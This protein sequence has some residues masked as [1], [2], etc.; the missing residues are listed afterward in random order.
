MATAGE[1]YTILQ[2]AVGAAAVV[3]SFIGGII[4]TVIGLKPRL[5][6][7]DDEQLVTKYDLM[8]AMNAFKEEERRNRHDLYG[9]MQRNSS[10]FELD[11]DRINDN[12]SEAAKGTDTRLRALEVSIARL[13]PRSRQAE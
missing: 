1:G 9:Q 12:I 4:M 10:A 11:L 13:Q 8:V 7:S 6:S 2:Y 5:R 3:G